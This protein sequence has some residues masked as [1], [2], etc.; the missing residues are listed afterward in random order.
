MNKR[1]KR[2]VGEQIEP[3]GRR[4]APGRLEVLPRFVNTWNHD[5]PVEWDRLGTLERTRAWLGAKRLVPRETR[6]SGRG[7]AQLRE[8]REALRELAG[9]NQGIAPRAGALRIL[10]GAA[11]KATLR[12]DFDP[13]GQTTLEPPRGGID[14]AVAALLVMLH[15]GR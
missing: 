9:A 12:V 13:S 3:G 6:I 11:S 14:Q 4:K 15:E 1:D 10:R 8:L 7:A 2:R 5:S